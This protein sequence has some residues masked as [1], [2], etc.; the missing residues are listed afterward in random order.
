MVC[1][2]V[3]PCLD[4]KDGRVVKGV[5]FQNLK[6]NGHPV[7][8]ALHYNR[9]GADELCVLDISASKENR[10]PHLDM[11]TAIASQAFIPVSAGGG[12]AS[13]EDVEQT[14]GAGA[15]KITLNSQAVRDPSLISHTASVFGSQCI[16]LAIDAKRV[17]DS[18][19]VFTHAG[20]FDTGLDVL[21]W[22]RQGMDL[23]AGEI[24]LTS[25]DTDGMRTGFDIELLEAVSR[26][27]HV[28]LI[29]SGGAGKPEDF[30]RACQAGA[31]AVLAAG[32]FHDNVFSIEQVKQTMQQAGIDVRPMPE[33]EAQASF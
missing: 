3:I 17:G 9:E 11:L 7:E 28:P 20:E 26:I 14:L 15:D 8:A 27:S 16:V 29:A 4:V 10:G 33:P 32:I 30:V 25:M 12:I 21:D 24:L 6:D 1:V 13:R 22:A 23:G 31:D 19:R 18:W 2:R 5:K